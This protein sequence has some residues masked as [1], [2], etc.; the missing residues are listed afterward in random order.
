MHEVLAAAGEP[1]AAEWLA[2]A[3]AALMSPAHRIGD[4]T[5]RERYLAQHVDSRAVMQA[6]RGAKGLP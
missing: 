2:R 3:H 4:A 5:L 1:G 6:W